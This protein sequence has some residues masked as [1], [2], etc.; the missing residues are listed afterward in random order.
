MKYLTIPTNDARQARLQ[1]A[2]LDEHPLIVGP[3]W[4]SNQDL[5]KARLG[6]DRLGGEEGYK[7]DE[8]EGAAQAELIAVNEEI[9]ALVA[10]GDAKTLYGMGL[11]AKPASMYTREEEIAFIV[12]HGEDEW[13]RMLFEEQT[14]VG[15]A[16]GDAIAGRIEFDVVSEDSP[17]NAA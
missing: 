5:L 3:A 4:T 12:E 15:S 8:A 2:F 17:A 1:A 11:I 9:A 14:R 13:M 6:G 16:T 7:L 10:A